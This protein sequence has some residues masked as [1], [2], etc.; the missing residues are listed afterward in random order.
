MNDYL[1]STIAYSVLPPLLT[2]YLHSILYSSNILA[3]QH[4][5]SPQFNRDR[6]VIYSGL[7]LAYL[8]YTAFQACTTLPPTYYDVLGVPVN[9]TSSD[10]RSQ[11]KILYY[12][13]KSLDKDSLT[14][15]L[16]SLHPDKSPTST[17]NAFLVLR[18]AYQ[19]LLNPLKRN[20]YDM[21]GPMTSQWECP[22]PR[23][24]LL[25]GVGW[26]VLPQ[27]VVSFIA[28]QVWSLFGRGGQ[29]KYVRAGRIT[30]S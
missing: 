2:T 6:K 25:R 21:F 11:F 3:P 9:V 26:L 16:K 4:P 17:D 8:V 10:L 13:H 23:E 1:A 22:T 20:M 29:V 18:H 5:Q 27:Y 19:T 14:S 30:R 12:P 28:L 15:R 24:C 7:V